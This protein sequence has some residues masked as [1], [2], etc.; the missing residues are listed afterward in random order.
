MTL[1]LIWSV[2]RMM[3][4]YFGLRQLMI[5]DENSKMGTCYVQWGTIVKKLILFQIKHLFKHYCSSTLIKRTSSFPIFF[6]KYRGI[7]R[8]RIYILANHET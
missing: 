7:L 1:F 2:K 5:F 8:P 3:R 4:D 6:F